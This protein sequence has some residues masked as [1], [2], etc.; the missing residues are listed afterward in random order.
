MAWVYKSW[1][2]VGWRG[3]RWGFQSHG[4]P[5]HPGLASSRRARRASPSPPAPALRV[6][7]TLPCL[8]RPCP[9]P[10]L[11]G[12]QCH[13]HPQ[14][15][16]R[17]AGRLGENLYDVVGPT[18]QMQSAECDQQCPWNSPKFQVRSG[19]ESSQVPFPPPTHPPHTHTHANTCI[20]TQHMQ[21]PRP[22]RRTQ[23]SQLS[24]ISW[25]PG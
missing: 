11:P 15:R 16:T 6:P 10:H 7:R 5:L 1:E 4:R 12:T 21:P 17:Q 3:L 25:T 20:Q 18:N 13:H 24:L 22:R 9:P 19:L 8:Q 23:S 2:Q 14:L